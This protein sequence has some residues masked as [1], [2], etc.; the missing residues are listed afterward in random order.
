MTNAVKLFEAR[1]HL[2]FERWTDLNQVTIH[3]LRVAISFLYSHTDTKKLLKSFFDSLFVLSFSLLLF[4]FFIFFV[5]SGSYFVV[6]C[7]LRS[8]PTIVE[9]VLHPGDPA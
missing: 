7:Y 3:S 4:V 1:V 8:S 9:L 2:F 6:A 5:L